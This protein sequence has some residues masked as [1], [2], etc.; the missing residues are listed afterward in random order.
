MPEGAVIN[1]TFDPLNPIQSPY[2]FFYPNGSVVTSGYLIN[3][4]GYDDPICIY[5]TKA[6]EDN[7]FTN[8]CCESSNSLDAAASVWLYSLI[9]FGV[10]YIILQ[11]CVKRMRSSNSKNDKT[12]IPQ[13]GNL[14]SAMMKNMS[15]CAKYMYVFIFFVSITAMVF[16][17]TIMPKSIQKTLSPTDRA[18]QTAMDSF[19]IPVEEIFAFI[20]DTMTVKVGYAIASMRYKD[21]N[22][23]L[24]ISVIGGAICGGIAFI[25]MVLIAVNDDIA[26]YILNPS[27]KSNQILIKNGCTLVPSTN[28]I[29]QNAKVYWMLKSLVWIPSFMSK[30]LA[31]F[32]IGILELFPNLFPGIIN[33]VVPISLWFGLLSIDI[34][35]LTILGISSCASTWV[36]WLTY[37]IYLGINK[38]IRKK[39]KLKCL[40]NEILTNLFCCCCRRDN[41]IDVP[42]NTFTNSNESSNNNNADDGDNDNN[43]LS[44]S[45]DIRKTMQ[46]CVYDGFQLMLVDLAIQLSTSV[47]TYVAATE[48]FEIAF[49]I[50]APQAAYWSFGPQY[51]VGSMFIFKMMG[52]TLIASGKHRMFLG[53]FSFICIL[54]ISLMIGAVLA[55]YTTDIYTAYNFGSS[56]CIYATKQECGSS[57]ASIFAGKDSLQSVFD[58]FGWVVG[59]NLIFFLLR[60]SLMICHDFDFLAKAAVSSFFLIYLPAIFIAKF[61]IQTSVSYYVAMYIPHFAL[62]VAFGWRMYRHLQCLKNGSDGPWTIHTRKMSSVSHGSDGLED[63]S[64]TEDNGDSLNTVLLLDKN[65]NE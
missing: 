13:R 18:S 41:F 20:E 35:P 60:G 23:L 32:F 62:I 15:P 25:L 7:S 21:L 24:N 1:C 4:D 14:W 57:Y 45:M 38:N 43:A 50:A 3:V 63:L 48:H 19:L 29:L 37:F 64:Y 34:Y 5:E 33:A 44:S 27:E 17:S 30:G 46:E 11:V 8:S 10:P 28:D 2:K 56:A 58:A 53:L 12:T 16:E 26:G 47:T 52:S 39:Y 40:C 9:A 54:T 61:Y 55:A 49:K 22:I 42:Y 36:V 65:V 59:F 6:C 31:G 51:L